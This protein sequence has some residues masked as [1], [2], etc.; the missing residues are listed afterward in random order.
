M[1]FWN[2]GYF[3]GDQKNNLDISDDELAQI[4]SIKHV[5]GVYPFD[6]FDTINQM[7]N[8]STT[9]VLLSRKQGKF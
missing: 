3:I 7:Q 8:V 4:K 5:K 6:V 9:S 2:D 1:L